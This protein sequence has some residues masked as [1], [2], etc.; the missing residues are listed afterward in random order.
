MDQEHKRL[1]HAIND[2]IKNNSCLN[3]VVQRYYEGAFE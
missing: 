1:L 2:A 3:T